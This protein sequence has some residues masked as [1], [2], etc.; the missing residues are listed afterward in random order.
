MG[1]DRQGGHFC[2]RTHVPRLEYPKAQIRGKDAPGRGPEGQKRWVAR[3][4][5][6]CNISDVGRRVGGGG[7]EEKGAGF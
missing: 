4:R 3:G 6:G 2:R 5:C 7:E 1:L